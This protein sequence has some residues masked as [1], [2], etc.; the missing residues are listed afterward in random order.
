MIEHHIPVMLNESLDL[1]ITDQ[2]GVYF[3]ATLGFGG[4]T[5]EMLKRLTNTGRIVAADVDTDAFEY[6]QKKFLKEDRVSIYNYNYS[7][8]DV[9]AKIESLK[10][11]D[12]VLA[13]LGV[14][15]F[16]LD[17]PESGFTFRTEAPLDL[18]MDKTKEVSAA[19]VI[20]SYDEE[21]LADIFFNY[22]EEK[23]SRKIA[24][25]IVQKRLIKK[26]ETTKDISEI[27]SELVPE[28]YLRK[29]LTRI[30]QAL[31]ICV[32]DELENLK[33]FLENSVKVLKKGGRIVV[34]SYHSL[35]DRIVK[36]FFKSN[37]VVNLSPKED[38]LGL[39]KK[40]TSLKLINKKPIVPSESEI[41]GNYRARSAKLRAAERL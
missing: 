13:D 23:N 32:N 28:N 22:G 4:H 34:I 35:E 21:D 14:S 17:N 25:S 8:I 5:T 10:Y 26:I 36:D 30:F 39:I 2:S 19:D 31:R 11:F 15:S 6:S 18:R 29:T 16:Q 1:L 7:F 33:L 37:T 20:N 9:I 41:R 27:I 40:E 12:G 3:D 24:R 38:P